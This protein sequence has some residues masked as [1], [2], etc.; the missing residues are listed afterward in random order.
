MN[1]FVL[2]TGRCGSTTFWRA[3]THVTNYTSAHESRVDQLGH[4]RLDYPPNH[5]EID[6]RLSWFL[7]KLD[8]RY[9][10][11]AFYVHLTRD[12]DAVAQ[13]LAKH[14]SR[15][16]IRA[17][18]HAVIPGLSLDQNPLEVTAD[19]CDT[20][21]ENIA[22]FLKDKPRVLQFALE[23]AS[24]DFRAFWNAIGAEG[25]LSAALGEFQRKHNQTRLLELEGFRRPEPMRRFM[26]KLRRTIRE[27][28]GMLRDA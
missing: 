9:G 18:R 14:Y 16:I 5:I 19:Y 10:S 25:D 20:V 24:A 11:D 17:Y 15:G 22:Q 26:R 4:A 21:N 13:S 3:C 8:H 27:L 6:N 1:V 7:G 2:N 12:R 28:P 23:S